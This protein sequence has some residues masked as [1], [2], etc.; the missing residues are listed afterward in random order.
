[1]IA[2][3]RRKESGWVTTCGPNTAWNDPAA[4]TE[5]FVGSAIMSMWPETREGNEVMA[6]WGCVLWLGS[7]RTDAPLRVNSF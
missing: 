2:P 4:E 1:M 5:R 6:I 7:G 3:I